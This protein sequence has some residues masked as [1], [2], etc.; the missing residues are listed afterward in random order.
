MVESLSTT[1]LVQYNG[2][3]EELRVREGGVIGNNSRG[4]GLQSVSTCA[5]RSSEHA[6]MSNAVL[7]PAVRGTNHTKGKHNQFQTHAHTLCD[8]HLASLLKYA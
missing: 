2:V 5:L 8:T 6:H 7:T 4:Q 1:A 3:L